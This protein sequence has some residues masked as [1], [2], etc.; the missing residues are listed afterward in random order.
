MLLLLDTVELG[1]E[2]SGTDEVF[3]V[4]GFDSVLELQT[5]DFGF[6]DHVV[7]DDLSDARNP[8]NEV[9]VTKCDCQVGPLTF[10]ALGLSGESA[11]EKL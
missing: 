5:L 8:A 11:F 2:V 6:D 1:E 7:T 9:T 10:Q 4:F 3:D